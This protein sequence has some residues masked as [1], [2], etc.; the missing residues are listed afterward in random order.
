M[1]FAGAFGPVIANSHQRSFETLGCDAG[2]LTEVGA[3]TLS[4]A[5]KFIRSVRG[6]VAASL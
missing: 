6:A 2:C 3:L 1:S 4:G 5:A